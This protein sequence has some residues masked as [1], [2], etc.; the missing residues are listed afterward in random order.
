MR[1]LL[2]LPL[3]LSV[4]CGGDDPYAGP[5]GLD[6]LDFYPVEGAWLQYG[7]EQAPAD[8]PFLMIEVGPSSWELRQGTDW[9]EYD[10][11]ETLDYTTDDGLVLQG[12]LLLPAKL[13]EGEIQDGVEILSLGEASVY[14]GS[15]PNAATTVVP[16][17]R[18]AG[19]WIFAPLL[20]PAQMSLDGQVW[21]LV[22]YL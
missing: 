14:Y 10:S 9:A 15:F 13:S 5:T 16:D 19:E 1:A 8:G 4:A 21:E 22:Y 17:G 11:T 18:F 20:G 6:A 3:L 12:S 2:S 7:P